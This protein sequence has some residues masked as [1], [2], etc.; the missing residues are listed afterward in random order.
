MEYRSAQATYAYPLGTGSAWAHPI[1]LTRIYVAAPPGLDFVTQYPELGQDLSGYTAG[2]WSSRSV[3]RIQHATGAAYAVEE[4]VDAVSGHV[5]RVT[6]RESN[7]AE[8]LLITTLPATSPRTLAALQ[9]QRLER[10]AGALSWLFAP[11]AALAVWLAVWRYVMQRLLKVEYR[12]RERRFW[13]EALGW[14]LLYPL[15]NGVMLLAGV[16]L[17]VLTA[18]VGMFVAAPILLIT[19]LGGISIF[20]FARNRAKALGVSRRQA[21]V[22]Y[23]TVMVMANALFLCFGIFYLGLLGA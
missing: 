20:F 8:D 12:W 22:A 11:L 1:E 19:V 5:W 7:S 16:V 6:Y 15:T 10:V 2:G 17:T 13:L 21:A 23:V 4:A 14:G 3:P 9:R 18:G